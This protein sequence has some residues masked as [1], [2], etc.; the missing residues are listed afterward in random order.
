MLSTND[1]IDHKVNSS[2]T[3]NHINFSDTRTNEH[4]DHKEDSSIAIQS[5]TNNYDFPKPN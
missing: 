3:N 1:N 2:R 4:I 5:S